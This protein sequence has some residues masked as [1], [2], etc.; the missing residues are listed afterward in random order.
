M[1]HYWY[2]WGFPFYPLINILFWVLLIAFLFRG[3]GRWHH[4]G[5]DYH[6]DRSAE[7]ILKE[8]FAHGEINEKEYKERMSVLKESQNK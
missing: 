7:E 6:E 5:H 3:W 2:F 8:R 4:H 1:W